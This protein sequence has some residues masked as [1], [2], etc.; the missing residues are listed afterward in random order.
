MHVYA[1]NEGRAGTV[2]KYEFAPPLIRCCF[3]EIW[4]L[5]HQKIWSVNKKL[6]A[7]L[8][9]GRKI[10]E[11]LHG[12]FEDLDYEEDSDEE[13]IPPELIGTAWLFERK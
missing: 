7:M 1:K 8:W 9:N 12:G 2:N 10:N 11:V 13:Y 5:L 4:L 6:I 3:L